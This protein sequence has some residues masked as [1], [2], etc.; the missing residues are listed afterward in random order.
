M[1][2]IVV[3]AFM[4]GVLTAAAVE[5]SDRAGP[6]ES[7]GTTR[8]A[9]AA[10][11]GGS[12]GRRGPGSDRPSPAVQDTKGH[13]QRG[14]PMSSFSEFSLLPSL[15]SSL[16]K[17]DLTQPTEVQARTIPALLDDR[18]LVAVSETGSGKTL[19]Y[20]LPMLH[21]LKTLELDGSAVSSAGRPRG[22]VVV[23]GREL[24]DQVSR[25]FKSLTH[26]TRLRVRTVLG[27]SHKQVAL[28]NV[29]GEFEVLVATP[30]RLI[31]LLDSGEVHLDDVRM[32]VFDEADRMIDHGFLPVARRVVSQCQAG[33]QLAMF[34]ATL[35]RPLEAVVKELYAVKPLLVRTQ[36]SQHTVPTLEVENRTVVDGRR[37]DVLRAVFKEDASTGSLLFA[38]TRKQCDRIADWLESEG[39]AYAVYRGQMDRIERRANLRRFRRGEVAV[40]IA[41]DLGSRGLDIER[42][43]RV[44]NVHLPQ[45]VDNYL[46]RVGRTAR[47]G[48][49]G[50]VIN[51]VTERDQPLIEKLKNLK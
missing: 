41:T 9:A 13:L 15:I 16:A 10:R 36:G 37:F 28:R 14:C 20:V 7:Q 31:Q 32:L 19:A 21:K 8:R 4:G 48:R 18:P 11:A 6:S 33:T 23:P 12:H 46:H 24:G 40:M 27:G 47:A 43:Q 25:V 45:D 1:L 17:Q 30:G 39:I 2:L 50:L 44:I 26:G 35:P 5:P 3:G 49:A 34:S 42:V 22:L 51:L 29:S 38:N